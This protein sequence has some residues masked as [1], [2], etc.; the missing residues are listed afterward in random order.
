[1]C[2]S[3]VE[4]V[5]NT[6]YSKYVTWRIDE[7]LTVVFGPQTVGPYNAD[8]ISVQTMDTIGCF[9]FEVI[10]IVLAVSAHLNTYVMG[11]R[12]LYFCQFF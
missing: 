11:L 12:P 8:N 4:Y 10:I 6:F 7:S 9:Q 5:F 1:M 3:L 2:H